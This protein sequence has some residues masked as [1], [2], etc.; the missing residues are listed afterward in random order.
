MN[1]IIQTIAFQLL[2]LVIYDFFLKKETFFNWNR[3]YLLLTPALS[4]VLPFIQLESFK[5]TV[6]Q[7]YV[8][9]LPEI[10]LTP[11]N[12]STTVVESSLVPSLNLW[13]WMLICGS[14]LSLVWF[15][16][17]LIQIYLLKKEGDTRYYKNYT[18]I[19][20][21][22][23]DTAFSFFKNIFIGKSLLKKQHQ[24]I[25][26]H[27]LV[28]IK[29]KHSLDLLFFEVLRIL[30]WFNPLIYIYQARITEL[31][32]FIAD[33][34]TVKNN[35]KEH[36]QLLLEEVFKTERI[37]FINQFFNH[38]LI[39]K[40]IV[41]LQKSKS[42]KVWK[43]KYL[44]MIPLV[45][46]M[47]FYT[48]CEKEEDSV[49]TEKQLSIEEQVKE[50]QAAIESSDEELSPE[51]K[52]KIF[53]LAHTARKNDYT[54]SGKFDA[55]K[56]EQGEDIPFT[57]IP[58]KPMFKD[59]DGVSNEQQFD[60]FKEKLDNHVRA[61]FK[62]PQEAQEAGIQGR[63]FVLFRINIDGTVSVTNSRAPSEI[64]DAEARRIIESLPTLIPGKDESGTARPVT[65]A[66]PIAFKLK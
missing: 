55:S 38:S 36:Y 13:Q 58:V 47:L 49:V 27:E 33:A 51:L 30:F 66:Y 8:F 12:N 4:I 60:C 2:F 19:A 64:L 56:I 25:I 5:T 20:V 44:L 57:V 53:S 24:H 14:L 15:L 43:L 9:L 23:D 3:A 45:V 34:K 11:N 7:N 22:K 59:C 61:T 37:S 65:F 40:R 31:H 35:K 50:L 46:G 42:K 1:Y 62:Y 39:K 28:H 21:N 18:R 10:V 63:V 54:T 17:K 29:E 6:P 26:E 52:K 41:M 16:Y 48:S 32:E